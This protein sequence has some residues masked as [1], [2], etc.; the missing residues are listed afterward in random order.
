MDVWLSRLGL[1]EYAPKFI[2]EKITLRILAGMEPAE[3]KELG[4]LAYGHRHL[5]LREARKQVDAHDAS[6][7]PGVCVMV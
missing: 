1:A 3:L 2:E 5:I 7:A 4:V 6:Q